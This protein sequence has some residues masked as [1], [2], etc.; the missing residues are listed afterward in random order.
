MSD[1]D[2]FFQ[3]TGASPDAA[4]ASP[5]GIPLPL[6]KSSCVYLALYNPFSGELN[7]T[8]GDGSSATFDTD[9]I[10]ILK[11]FDADSVGGYFNRFIKA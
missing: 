4:K 8:F 5:S 6:K 3:Q 7:V 10:T 9:L 11:W 1:L 2:D